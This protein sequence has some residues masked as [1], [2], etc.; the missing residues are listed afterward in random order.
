M[1]I[2]GGLSGVLAGIVVAL[3]AFLIGGAAFVMT[4]APV[5]IARMLADDEEEK[6]PPGG[7]DGEGSSRVE[8]EDE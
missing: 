1:A 8:L 2:G 5:S 3:L 7:S 6:G 4:H